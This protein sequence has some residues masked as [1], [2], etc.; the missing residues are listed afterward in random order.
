MHSQT[1]QVCTQSCRVHVTLSPVKTHAFSLTQCQKTELRSSLIFFVRHHLDA[2]S[3]VL[4]YSRNLLRLFTSAVIWVCS[5]GLPL[6]VKT[7]TSRILQT[8]TPSRAT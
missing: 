6:K 1:L 3:K 4:R 8:S 7:R 5:D 2:S